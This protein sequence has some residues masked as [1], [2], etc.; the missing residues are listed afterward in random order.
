MG[1]ADIAKKIV[2]GVTLK[3]RSVGMDTVRKKEKNVFLSR[4][5]IIG[6]FV[7]VSCRS[8]EHFIF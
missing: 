2:N 8:A 7:I 4:S 1:V 6:Y 5:F 3:V